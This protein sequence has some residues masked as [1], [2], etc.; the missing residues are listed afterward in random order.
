MKARPKLFT[1]IGQFSNRTSTRSS[2]QPSKVLEDK[3]V[4]SNEE[5]LDL[6]CYFDNPM[7]TLYEPLKIILDKQKGSN[8]KSSL[9]IK[10]ISMINLNIM[11][12]QSQ[13]DDTPN[14]LRLPTVHSDV[15]SIQN[16]DGGQR[17]DSLKNSFH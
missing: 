3:Q 9:L 17:R 1:Y 6:K 14:E 2:V 16:Y 4:G 8:K 13:P 15:T 11:R 5:I 10:P 12:S 7:T